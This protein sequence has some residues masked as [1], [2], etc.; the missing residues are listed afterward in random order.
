MTRLE[1][2]AIKVERLHKLMEAEK[3]DAI[4]LKRQDDFSWITAGMRRSWRSSAAV[5]E[6]IHGM[7]HQGKVPSS[8][9]LFL[10][11][12]SV[13]ITALRLLPKTWLL[14]SRTSGH[15]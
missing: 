7:I 5:S 8:R 4:Y 9:S 13:L 2:I 6:S 1:E 15:H 14:Q 12:S 3:L 10:P 11:D